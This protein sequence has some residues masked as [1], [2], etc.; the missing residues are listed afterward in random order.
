MKRKIVSGLALFLLLIV[1]LPCGAMA[2]EKPTLIHI[3]SAILYNATADEVMYSLNAE[4][5]LYPAS[6]VK[7]MTAVLALEH[8]AAQPDAVLTVPYEA[9][10]AEGS[11]AGLLI[12]EKVRADELIAALIVYN[13][14]DA[15]LTLAMDI[16]GSEKDFVALMNEKAAALGMKDTHYENAT[17]L[18][19]A[20]MVTTA[21]DTLVLAQYAY[22]TP[23]Y[24]GVCGKESYTMS[25]TNFSKERVLYNRNY[26]VSRLTV[27]RYYDS[28]VTG[29]NYGS[30]YEAGGNVVSSMI[31]GGAQFF[32]VVMGGDSMYDD[33]DRPDIL[34]MYTF[35][36]AGL[37][38]SWARDSF[39]YYRAVSASQIV[40]EIP[41]TFGNDTDYVAL[42][43]KENI[44]L[45]IPIGEEE[46]VSVTW[47]FDHEKMTAPVTAGE[48]AG[49]LTV[50]F[51]DKTVTTELVTRSTVDRS[52]LAYWADEVVEFV[53]SDTFRKLAA[54]F[55][56]A[57]LVYIFFS[58]LYRGRMRRQSLERR[59]Q[60]REE[61][62]A[63]STTRIITRTGNA[64]N[65]VLSLGR[66]GSRS[67]NR[68]QRGKR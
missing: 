16:A 57:A 22:R 15:A 37:L 60:A 53:K 34:R 40:A 9:A 11:A 47:E 12:G 5:K 20:R 2:A 46:N 21:A 33:P 8:Y 64:E 62:R 35:I 25:Q 41:V 63:K 18:H 14:N 50:T 27:T 19:H 43:P 67:A 1:L 56:V 26:L 32:T 66:T 65:D 54:V 28:T 48:R 13:A 4:A 36:G 61:D 29:M 58:A 17:G 23:G 59:R 39:F 42:L 38:N 6:F 52:V 3:R 51:G 24:M 68:D 7:I 44:D 30:T 45:F 49:V 10:N 55:A 31:H